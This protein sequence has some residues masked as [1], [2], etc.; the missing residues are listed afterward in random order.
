MKFYNKIN[1]RNIY[2]IPNT[3]VLWNNNMVLIKIGQNNN[4]GIGL[5]ERI[6]IYLGQTI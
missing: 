4:C 2:I 6:C 3:K 5:V 1:Q